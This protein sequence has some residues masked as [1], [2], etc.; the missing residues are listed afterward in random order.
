MFGRI[1][2]SLRARQVE[3]NGDAAARPSL[4][5]QRQVTK[6]IK[7]NMWLLHEQWL[8]REQMLQN[9]PTDLMRDVHLLQPTQTVPL[10]D[11]NSALRGNMPQRNDEEGGKQPRLFFSPAALVSMGPDGPCGQQ[12]AAMRRAPRSQS[13]RGTMLLSSIS[14]SGSPTAL[15]SL[16]LRMCHAAA[17]GTSWVVTVPGTT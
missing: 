15:P 6:H 17:R 14:S 16:L 9:P 2:A 7:T 12:A 10:L 13:R 5:P 4:P 11:A 3:E 8:L 1:L